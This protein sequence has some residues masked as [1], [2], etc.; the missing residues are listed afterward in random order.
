MVLAEHGQ[1]GFTIFPELMVFMV[2]AFG[3]SLAAKLTA[4]VA[5]VLWI[6]AAAALSASIAEGRTRWVILIFIVVLPAH[7]A[8]LEV[9]HYAEA[10]AV[11]RPFAEAFVLLGL[12]L[13]GF[14]R[15]FWAALPLV[16]AGLFHPLMALPGLAIYAWLL[17]FDP[18]TR[19]VKPI[20]GLASVGIG[21]ACLVGAAALGVPVADRLFTAVDPAWR[22][23]L[24]ARSPYL[25]VSEWPLA[26]WTRTIVQFATV[27]IAARLV[28]GPVRSLFAAVAL[29]AA[30]GV[31]T[32][33]LFGDA[34][35]SLL[36]LQIQP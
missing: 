24:V 14:G 9:F 2:A 19:V 31:L 16:I 36:V 3:S 12:A 34:L 32:S 18:Q 11:P 1:S 29:V 23:I 25:F 33:L 6:A 20:V 4:L 8:G 22:D 10:L 7:Y 15:R 35:G 17:L 13:F 30:A 5:L 27:A 26:D 28:S 21:L